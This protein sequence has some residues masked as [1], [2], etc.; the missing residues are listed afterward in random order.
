MVDSEYSL[1]TPDGVKYAIRALLA[2][3]KRVEDMNLPVAIYEMRELKSEVRALRRAF[4]AFAFS[5]VGSAVVFAFTVF[6]LLGKH[7]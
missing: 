5:V 1:D 6:T 3:R 2:H 4:Y 7:P